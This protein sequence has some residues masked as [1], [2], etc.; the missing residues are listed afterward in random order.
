MPRLEGIE[1]KFLFG[2]QVDKEND[3]VFF[4]DSEHLYLDKTDG[5]QYISVTTLLHE[6]QNAFNAS[7]FSKYKALESLVDPDKFSWVKQGLLSTQIWKP[8][9]LEKFGIDETTFN[10]KVEEILQSWDK[11]RDE[12]CEHGSYIH[13]LLE[14]SFYGK[15]K[16]DL[17]QYGVPQV[18]GSYTCN[19]GY[20]KLDLDNGIYPEFL[21]SWISPE[22]LHIAGQADLICKS[23]NDIDILDWKT[24]KEIKRRSFFNSSKKQNVKLKFPLNT[25]EDCNYNLYMLQ[26][27][28]YGYMLQKLNPDF[29]IRSLTIVHIQRDG[30]IKEYPVEYRKDDIERVIKHYAKQLEIKKKLE[31]DI[32][33]IK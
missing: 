3:S 19:K 17:S 12:A 32:P 27:S 26:L 20:Y 7:F 31:R 15:D 21:M 24:N 4:N 16:F 11:T 1:Q 29:N 25:L 22:G 33:F 28:M 23:G 5:S 8:E 30:K 14:T 13:N 18:C 2:K 9:L 6:Y 10:E